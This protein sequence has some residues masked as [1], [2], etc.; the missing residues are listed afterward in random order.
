MAT[1][2]EIL[3]DIKEGKDIN[4]NM[5]LLYKQNLPL[6]RSFGSRYIAFMG[7]EDYYQECYIALHK[8]VQGYDIKSK[9]NFIAY[10]KTTLTRHL[11]RISSNHT[12]IKIGVDDKR[13]LAK[14]NHLINNNASLTD[15]DICDILNCSTDDLQR[16]R[17]YKELSYAESAENSNADD[18]L[19]LIDIIKDSTNIEGE[20]E[21][22]ETKTYLLHIWDFIHTICTPVQ[23]YILISKYKKK[24]SLN[25]MSEHLN[26]TISNIYQIEQQAI[27]RLVYDDSFIKWASNID[28]AYDIAY[29][30]SYACWK[31]NKASAVEYAAEIELLKNRSKAIDKRI[32][33]LKKNLSNATSYYYGQ[34]FYQNLYNDIYKNALLSK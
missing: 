2:E 31:Y 6:M 7:E 12:G 13:L 33:E 9:C 21:E 15:S 1:N 26:C 18:D 11:T 23:E 30:Y 20:Y 19:R 8:A 17:T 22:A 14:Y 32:K 34:Q 27:K 3:K 16:I 4:N 24:T 25:E 28:T 5:Y 29:Q 10:L